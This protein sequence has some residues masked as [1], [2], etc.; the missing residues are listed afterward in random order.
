[1]KRLDKEGLE[2]EL[3]IPYKDDKE[4]DD[5]IYE[6]LASMERQA[7][8]YNCFTESDVSALDNSERSWG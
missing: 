1:M 3:T 7:D 4:L 8:L 2:Y 5:S 6:L